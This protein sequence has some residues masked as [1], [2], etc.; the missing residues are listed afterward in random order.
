MAFHYYFILYGCLCALAF[1][2]HLCEG[3]G[4]GL[5]KTTDLLQPELQAIVKHLMGGW[6]PNLG[7]LQVWQ[8]LL[9]PVF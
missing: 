9:T 8:V 6:E 4:R 2:H 3:A 1:T 7:F 5:K